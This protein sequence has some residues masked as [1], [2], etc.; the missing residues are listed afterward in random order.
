MLGLIGNE[1]KLQPLLELD[2]RF[3]KRRNEFISGS[4]KTN[5]NIKLEPGVN[6]T[7]KDVQKSGGDFC[8]SPKMIYKN[9]GKE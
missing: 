9:L 6:F 5:D 2:K 8:L 4:S 1:S 7:F 3:D